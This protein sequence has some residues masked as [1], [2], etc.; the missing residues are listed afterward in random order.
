MNSAMA[1]VIVKA[2]RLEV[3]TVLLLLRVGG[4]FMTGVCR[5]VWGA[6]RESGKGYSM[7]VY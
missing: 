7:P 6:V 5:G 3:A 1:R 4:V 2:V